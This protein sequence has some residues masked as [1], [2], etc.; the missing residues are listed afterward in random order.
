MDTTD[1]EDPQ[2]VQLAALAQVKA[3]QTGYAAPPEIDQI[4]SGGTS[5]TDTLSSGTSA[6]IL[7]QMRGSSLRMESTNWRCGTTETSS[8]SIRRPGRRSGPA[9]PP[10]GNCPLQAGDADRRPPGASLETII[11]S[12]GAPVVRTAGGPFKLVMQDDGNLVVYDSTNRF[13][14]GSKN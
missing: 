14:W 6:G 1:P 3:E 10:P 4:I 12:S 9:A 7:N 11:A 8:L 2:V 5:V 13:I